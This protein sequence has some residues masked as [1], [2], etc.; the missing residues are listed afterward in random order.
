[1]PDL[2]V[3]QIQSVIGPLVGHSVKTFGIG[4]VVIGTALWC[5]QPQSIVSTTFGVLYLVPATAL[6]GLSGWAGTIANTVTH[7]SDLADFA[8]LMKRANKKL[9]DRILLS[10]VNSTATYVS[11]SEASDQFRQW[12]QSGNIA[13]DIEKALVDSVL[14]LAAEQWVNDLFGAETVR[15]LAGV[16]LTKTQLFIELV[17]NLEQLICTRSHQIAAEVERPIIAVLND[18]I[19]ELVAQ[20]SHTEKIRQLSNIAEHTHRVTR[21]IR[22]ALVLPVFVLAL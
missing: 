15:Q 11:K 12:I 16:W 13:K 17:T 8:R 21:L 5:G 18:A 10:A 14:E 19:D 22:L 7:K 1:M 2:P 4:S 3:R 9:I 20:V 6:W